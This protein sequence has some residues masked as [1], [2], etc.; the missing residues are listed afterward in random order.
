MSATTIPTFPDI[1]P[2]SITRRAIH[3]IQNDEITTAQAL[4]DLILFMYAYQERDFYVF[5]KKG[6][7]INEM[8][9]QAEQSGSIIFRKSEFHFYVH[10]K[11]PRNFIRLNQ[12]YSKF[13]WQIQLLETGEMYVRTEICL[14]ERIKREIAIKE[15]K[16]ASEDKNPLI[17]QPN[18]GGLGLDFVK[19]FRLIRSWFARRRHRSPGGSS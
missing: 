19:F 8:I 14:S 5:H 10:P 1:T 7:P 3:E 15:I 6:S 9:K 17:L 18:I 4:D 11:Y 13:D 12:E 2:S 16:E